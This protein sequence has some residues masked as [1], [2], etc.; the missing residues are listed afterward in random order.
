VTQERASGRSVADARQEFSTG[1]TYLDTATYGLPPRAA[2]EAV[3]RIEED[4]AC[5]RMAM[6]HLDACVARSRAAFADLLGITAD[7]VAVGPQVSHFVGAV[8]A[9]LPAGATVLVADGDVTSL[10]FPFLVAERR[11]VRVRSVPLGHLA[12]AVDRDVDLVAVSAV[13]S[14]DG[15]VV[16]LDTVCA[17]A[18]AHG[19][20]TLVDATQAAGWSPLPAERI[21]LLVCGGYKWLLG[22]RGT[23]FLAG[24]VEALAE[25]PP[26]AAGWYAGQDPWTSIYGGPL[27]L[28][29][30]ARRH[31]VSPA[32]PCWV[33]QAAALEL[34]TEVGVPALHRHDVGLANRFR[35]GLGL[36]PGDSAIASLAVPAG[37]AERLA[38]GGV[39]TA[40]RA[41]RMRCAFHLYTTEEGVDR[42]LDLLA[43]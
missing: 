11:G 24:T 3:L 17:A 32:W 21:D 18:S 16:P 14:A 22:P 40:A 27:R 43:D 9:S 30:D 29:A 1:A 34:L 8:A 26:L 42:A 31:D 23:C 33:G 10:L 12:A 28:A 19:A 5:G 2:T 38:R 13:Q 37:T 20:R 25:L 41:G 35:R 15:A 7:R 39:A 4:R 6:D 36:P